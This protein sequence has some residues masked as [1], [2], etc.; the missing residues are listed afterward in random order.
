M[1]RRHL[2]GV[3]KVILVLSGKGGVGKSV[4]SAT[5]AAQLARAGKQVGLIDADV[6]GPSA[7]LL[8][9]STSLPEEK[10]EGLTPPKVEGVKLM[11]VDLFASGRPVPL[12]GQG[13]SQVIL[14]L[15]ALTDWGELD[16]LIVDMPP[17]TGDIML[18]LTS[19]GRK[20]LEALVVT[21][22]DVL[23]T[24]VA[25]RVLELLR[26]GGIPTMGVLENMSRPS[27]GRAAGGGRGPRALAKEFGVKFLGAVSYDSKVTEAVDKQ[28]I[29][30]LLTT[31]FAKELRRSVASRLLR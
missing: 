2:K 11:S 27:R 23:S 18:T 25:H 13:A 8:F 30:A 4:V 21:M 14:E 9:N 17:A 29:G 15:L 12:T 7:A 26:S 31:L 19:V 28:D 24:S 6:Y 20:Q 16:F 5:L 3:G 1:I 10:Q 22:P